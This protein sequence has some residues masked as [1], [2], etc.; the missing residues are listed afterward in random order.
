MAVDVN[1]E[2]LAAIVALITT[3][4]AAYVTWVLS[5][6]KRQV[7]TTSSIASAANMSVDTML[8][9]L[10]QLRAEVAELTA[11]N[12]RLRA[13]TSRLHSEVQRL[14]TLVRDLGGS[15]ALNG[16]G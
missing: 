14:A 10:Q 4:F 12:Q 9:V 3:P 11:E 1:S 16:G 7:E 13:E 5:R 6:R 15:P 2:V 8:I